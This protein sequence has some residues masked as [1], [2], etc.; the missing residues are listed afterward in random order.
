MKRSGGGLELEMRDN[1]LNF[2][3]ENK[4]LW[5]KSRTVQITRNLIPSHPFSR[6]RRGWGM[7]AKKRQ[8]LELSFL[9]RVPHICVKKNR[10]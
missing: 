6:E 4:H 8:N 5:L 7:S 1:L 2:Q 10:D 9:K 3:C